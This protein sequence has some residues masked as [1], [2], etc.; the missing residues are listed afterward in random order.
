MQMIENTYNKFEVIRIRTVRRIFISLFL[1]KEMKPDVIMVI[2]GNSTYR[3]MQKYLE[4]VDKHKLEEIN[5]VRESN[6]RLI[7]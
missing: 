1:K 6:L 5:E 7:K 2:T 3:M 4:I